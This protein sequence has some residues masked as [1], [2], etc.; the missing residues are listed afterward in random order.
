[1]TK[2]FSLLLLF[3]TQLLAQPTPLEKN[4]YEKLTSYDELTKFVYQ[5]DSLSDILKVD[6][7]GKSVEERNLYAL[8]FS[9]S[10]FGEDTSKIKVLIFAQQHGNEQSGKEGALM[11]AR[12]L[13]RPD[14]KYLFDKI[15]LALIPQM[16]PDGSEKNLRQ[17]ANGI[18]LNRN[19]LILTEPE[20]IA[21]HKLFN[22][23]HFE[24]TMDVHEY[25]PFTESWLNF[26]YV[27]DFDE[28]I[29]TTT[30]PNVAEEIRNISNNE[31]LP[32]IEKYLNKRGYSFHN[33]ILGGPPGVELFRHSTYDINDGRQS[34]GIQNTFSFIMEG[35]NGRDSL[36]FIGR[37]ADG[38]AVGM[39]GF[40]EFIYKNKDRIKSFV[41]SER[42][43]LFSGREDEKV[44]IQFDHINVG[45]KLNLTLHSLSTDSDTVIVVNDYRPIV[46]SIYDVERPIGYLLPKK[47][48]ELYDWAVRQNLIISHFDFTQ[49]KMIQ[50]YFISEIDSI[51]FEGDTVVNPEVELR[52][53]QNKI[54][55]EEYYFIPTNQLKNNLI[56]IALESKSMLGLVTYKNYEHFLKAGEYFPVL[57]VVSK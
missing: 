57:R 40:L 28:Q 25:Y 3:S 13:I 42:E 31:F 49:D 21:L 17:N 47:L 20:T 50:Q 51:D 54:N 11:L 36:E 37:R 44:A 35:K 56:V 12:E 19:H 26:G 45:N 16:N 29:G 38:Q 9:N 55:E 22:E 32:F 46:Q 52:E 43:K 18:D 24:A 1:M 8:K 23:Y 10:I 39:L 14:N 2:Y 5:L 6:V 15:D 7:I 34:F 27:K 4:N 48:T 30:N 53:V 41:K 33:Y